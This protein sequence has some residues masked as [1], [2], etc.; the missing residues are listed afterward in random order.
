MSD[1]SIILHIED[2][3]ENRILVRRLLQVEGYTI[4]EAENAYARLC[5]F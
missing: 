2:N 1:P 4:L 5:K 3:P